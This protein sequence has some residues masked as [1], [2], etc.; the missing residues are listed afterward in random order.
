M[1]LVSEVV[2][3]EEL[4]DRALELAGEIAHGPSVAV[5]IMKRLVRESATLSLR[6]HVELEE[7]LQR[8]TF[9]TEDFAEGRTSFL[10]KREPVF[11]GR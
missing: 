3:T 2:P 4:A 1:G 6:Q 5:E 11:R 10:E 9:E 8:I 7:H